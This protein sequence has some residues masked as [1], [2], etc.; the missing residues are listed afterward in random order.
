VVCYS[1]LGQMLF[2]KKLMAIE[3]SLGKMVKYRYVILLWIPYLGNMDL[4]FGFMFLNH[5]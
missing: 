1:G 3:S 5:R 4:F 2:G